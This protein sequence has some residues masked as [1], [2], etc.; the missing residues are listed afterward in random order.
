MLF[1]SLKQMS[2]NPS[3]DLW[4]LLERV[5]ACEPGHLAASFYLPSKAFLLWS[6]LLLEAL[7]DDLAIL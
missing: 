5:P 7:H 6:L 1:H 3:V 4:C 2:Q